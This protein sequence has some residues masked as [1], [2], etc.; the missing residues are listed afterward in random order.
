MRSR[1]EP[2]TL[3]A[4]LALVLV[5]L[6]VSVPG[7][8]QQR[9]T[10][11]CQCVTRS[12]CPEG[13]LLRPDHPGG[14]PCEDRHIADPVVCCPTASATTSRVSRS[15]GNTA[16]RDGGGGGGRP[17]QGKEQLP[18]TSDSPVA[19]PLTL[20]PGAAPSL[21]WADEDDDSAPVI[22]LLPPPPTPSAPPSST[23]SLIAS[24]SSGPRYEGAA[25][26]RSKAGPESD[27]WFPEAAS[28]PRPHPHEHR[29]EDSSTRRPYEHRPSV[30]R[31]ADN[32]FHPPSKHSSNY[33][34]QSPP[35][36]SRPPYYQS[37]NDLNDKYRPRPSS[38]DSR[39]NNR[40]WGPPTL[41]PDPPRDRNPL[42]GTAQRNSVTTPSRR[43]PRPVGISER[44]C[45]EYA[46]LQ[47]ERVV[48]LP[49]VPDPKPSVQHVQ[50]CD[51]NSV[52]LVVGGQDARLHEFPHMAAIGYR[53]AGSSPRIEW[54]C[55]GSLISEM[56]VLTAAHC[57][58]TAQGPPIRVRLGEHNLES[59]DDGAKPVDIAVSSMVRHPGYQP[60]A[61][62]DDIGL[63]RL[64]RRVQ[65]SAAIRPACVYS[66]GEDGDGRVDDGDIASEPLVATGWGHTEQ[67]GEKSQ[68]LQKVSLNFVEHQ[69]CSN[70]YAADASTSSLSRGIV[71]ESQLCAGVLDGGRD[72]CQGD[73][74][75]PLQV[76][77]HNN[78]CVFH[79]I[80]ITSFG[81]VCAARN[82]PG[83]YTRVSKYISWIERHVWPE[84]RLQ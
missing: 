16:P 20:R 36:S 27:V 13:D 59:N 19:L 53:S 71:A 32:S 14:A 37:F 24:R 40:V 7:S 61:R 12:L 77:S 30:R 21:H 51:T 63:L 45:A 25:A 4:L 33:H 76:S 42:W 6:L 65:F 67:L 31:P 72:T 60:P 73:S 2:L 47:T 41:P 38:S 78:R 75:G 5:L 55:G 17:E 18:A 34:F 26:L 82:S 52:P 39:H 10:E 22:P 9:H 35:T 1:R 70:L 83:V 29:S 62:Y 57:T 69:T 44:K 23:P 74:G 68:V 79:I 80:G 28:Y 81:K 43:R 66:G 49:L 46:K 54:N 58:A 84:E 11:G 64:A 56:F 48:A 8:R 50:K 15:I 3:R